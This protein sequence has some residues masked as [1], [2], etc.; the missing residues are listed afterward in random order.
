MRHGSGARRSVRSGAHRI[1]M[2]VPSHSVDA[3]QEELPKPAPFKRSGASPASPP[4]P[5]AIPGIGSCHLRI[6]TQAKLC[7]EMLAE[8]EP[9][10]SVF[11]AT[12]R[13]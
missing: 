13:A 11:A 1:M 12:R 3:A 9:E 4:R 5:S 8:T 2:P 6:A 7:Q 10:G